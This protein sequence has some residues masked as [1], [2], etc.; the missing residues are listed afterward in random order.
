[1]GA[2]D[3]AKGAHLAAA[4]CTQRAVAPMKLSRE[5]TNIA[6]IRQSV[7]VVFGR[8]KN[9]RG[10]GPPVGMTAVSLVT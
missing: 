8:T 7:L 5:V 3:D 6:S 9:S 10:I 4:E 1:M 2:R